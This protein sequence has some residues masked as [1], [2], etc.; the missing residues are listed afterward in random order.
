MLTDYVL[1]LLSSPCFVGCGVQFRF[2]PLWISNPWVEFSSVH[3]GSWPLLYFV[4]CVM[5]PSRSIGELCVMLAEFSLFC[6]CGL[7]PPF[8]CE[9]GLLIYPGL[10]VVAELFWPR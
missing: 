3:A 10:G 6:S 4:D 8:H 9:F 5:L 1:G 2:G 7:F